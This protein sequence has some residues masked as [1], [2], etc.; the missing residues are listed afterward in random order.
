[1]ARSTALAGCF[2]AVLAV[3]LAA[4]PAPAQTT[5]TMEGGARAAALGG[6]GTALAGSAWGHA[7][8]ASWGALGGRAVAFYAT[9]GFGLSEMRLGALRYAEPTPWGTFAGGARTFGFDAYRETAFTLGYA[10]GVRLGTSRRVYAGLAARYYRLSLGER[11]D[12]ASYGSAGALGLSLGVLARP[13]PRLTL[14]AAATN[15]NGPSYAEGS[16]LAQTLSLGLAYQASDRLLVAADV[17][18]DIDFPLSV[19]AG[20]EVL[21]VEV[22]AVRVG[23]ATVPARVTAGIGLRLGRL[24]A[25]LAAER[26]ETLGWTPAAALGLQW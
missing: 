7:N 3:L 12:G 6:A 20:L 26:H 25:R 16:D 11:S 4:P 8:P 5:L 13:L 22:L 9:Q 15:V 21:P 10:R 24:R 2:A 1:M 19:R 23:V 17:F 18:K 14:G